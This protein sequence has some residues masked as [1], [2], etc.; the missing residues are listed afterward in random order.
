MR[1][2]C[3]AWRSTDESRPRRRAGSRLWGGEDPQTILDDIAASWDETTDK[4]GVDAQKAAY[5]E[6][7]AK[8]NAYPKM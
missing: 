1:R 5:A 6:W 2:R 3:A 7:A 8:P 4:I